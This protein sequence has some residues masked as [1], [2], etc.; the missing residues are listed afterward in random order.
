MIEQIF[1]DWRRIFYFY[2]WRGFAEDDCI[3]IRQS[4]KTLNILRKSFQL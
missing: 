3:I 2:D 4:K 1:Y